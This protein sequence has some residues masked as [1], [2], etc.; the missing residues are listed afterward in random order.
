MLVS[1]ALGCMFPCCR[2]PSRLALEV[3]ICPCYAFGKLKEKTGIGSCCANCIVCFLCLP[4]CCGCV[5]HQPV[6]TTI[7]SQYRLQVRTIMLSSCCD[8]LRDT[9]SI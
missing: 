8:V 1:S 5:M 7:R 3:L 2:F 4:M 6:R 9:Q